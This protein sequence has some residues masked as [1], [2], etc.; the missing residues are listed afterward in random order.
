M[1]YFYIYINDHNLTE[2]T[3]SLTQNYVEGAVG[4]ERENVETSLVAFLLQALHHD[5]RLF[6]KYPQEVNQD[7]EVKCWR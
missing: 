1:T 4:D 6:I 3:S 5:I 7:P 2:F